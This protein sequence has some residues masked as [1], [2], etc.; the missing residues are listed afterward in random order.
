MKTLFTLIMLTISLLGF[1]QTKIS[2]RVQDE[3]GE[4]VP[5]ANVFLLNTYDGTTSDVDG[6]FEFSSAETGKQ[7]FVVKFVGYQEFQQE[8]ELTGQSIVIQASIKEEINQL[9][10]VTITAGA[11]GANDE[12]RR[13][14]FRAV[15]IA[16]TAGATADIAGAL[17]TLPGTQKVGEEGRL[18][19]RG[20]DG[21]EARTFIDGL[22]VLDAYGPS[23]PNTP[24]RGRFLPF[25]FKGTSFST[26]GY[27]AEYGQALSSAL[28]LDSRDKSEIT[29]T[30]IG[31][32]SVGADVAHTQVWDRSSLAAKIQYT[33]I[34]PYFGL[35]NQ[36]IDWKLP[37]ASI[38][39]S[40]AF[41]QQ[42]GKNGLLKVFGN[43]NHANYSLYN[44]AIE[45]YSIKQLYDLTND[46]SYLNGF[47]RQSLND[48]WSVRGGVSYTFNKNDSYLDA[49][50]TVEVDK[51]IHVKAVAEGSLSDQVELRTG[52]ELIN[53]NYRLTVD[54]ADEVEFENGFDEVIS[55]GFV[56]ADVLAS[57]NFITRGG[58]RVEYNNLLNR[59]FVDPRISL[60]YKAG[61]QGQVS[62]AYGKF[63]QSPKNQYLRV[64]N[65]LESEKADHYILNY[66][67]ITNSRTFRVETYYKK[68]NDLI[69]F[70]NG[71][72]NDLTNYGTGYAKGL[73][74]F[75]RDNRS[76]RNVDYW[77]SYSYLDTE[78]DYLNTPFAV[79]PTFASAHNFSLVYKHFVSKLKSQ[80]GMTYSYTSGRPYNDPNM[81]QFNA[82]KTKSYQDLSVNISYLPTSQIIVYFSCTNVLGRDNIFGY[83]FSATPDVNGVYAGRA[84]RQPAPRF[85]FL[86]IFITLSKEK[87][88]N[89][90]PTL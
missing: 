85:L 1:A 11:F 71:D 61:K 76:I 58:L 78:R 3:R 66:Q 72:A 49:D 27:S 73:E 53:H 26:G 44:H 7:I 56:E 8:V 79:A 50:H 65:S 51:G 64:N 22:V 14:I 57:N 35:I 5:G 62:L 46:Y 32:M 13:T 48:K 89:Q 10:A 23:A 68:Y 41:R 83:E 40:S 4:P 9:E 63:R 12:S 2:G 81:D 34:R 25:M 30:D 67:L 60:A 38:E 70:N 84:I 59:V 36:E 17:N 87:S 31:I 47:Y 29:R 69:K 54:P 21:N 39:A 43:F 52:L 45:D 6:K 90:L 55:A 74:L 20:G 77:V 37:P 82:E 24:S 88:V 19:V 42:I 28:V 15:D 75:W 16:T 86:G 18:F 80:F 33:N